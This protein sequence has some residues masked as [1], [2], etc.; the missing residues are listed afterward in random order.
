MRLPAPGRWLAPFAVACLS[1]GACDQVKSCVG[2][3][4]LA[5]AR[6]IDSS[7]PPITA[8]G[9]DTDCEKKGAGRELEVGP[10]KK[11]ASI[12]E[13][14]F[15]SLEAGDTV[16]IYHRPEPYREKIAIGG[17][18]RADAPIRV[19]GV[20][21]PN[22]ELPVLDGDG[23]TTR[24]SME[25]PF[26]GHQARGVVVVGWRRSLGWK[27]QTE[28]VVIEGLEIRNGSPAHRFK[29]KAGAEVAYASSAAGIFVQRGSH[30]V[31]RGNV[32]HDNANGLFVGSAGGEELTRDVLIERNYVFDNGSTT[33]YYEHNVY[34]EASG[35]VYQF[36]HFG[37][38]KRGR[39]GT[40]GGNIKER[41]ARVTIR[42]NWIEDGGHLIDLV[43]A[44]E[45]AESNLADPAFHESWVYGN[46]LVR[47]GVPGG[48]LVH[49]GGDSDVL[50]HYRKGTLHFFHN[51][52]VI[53][54]GAHERYAKSSIFELSTNDE[55]LDSANN[56]FMSDLPDPNRPIHLLGGRD[57]KTA[58]TASF[59]GDWIREGIVPAESGGK[60]D[61]KVIAKIEGFEGCAKGAD[62]RFANIDKRDFQP[63]SSSP[64]LSK[65]IVLT[66]AEGQTVSFEYVKPG[67][68]RERPPEASPTPGA[69]ALPN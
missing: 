42:Y 40:L 18:G 36:N 66:F 4:P 28:H 65:G 26:D 31:L 15:E 20:K 56:V 11:Y 44:Q 68:R 14:P 38:P 53:E 17:V 37:P 33:D 21:G 54:N 61:V 25:F 59:R 3:K 35:V 69:L 19:C 64:F 50:D 57:G 32:V 34:N 30:I 52:V 5:S 8:F 1:L 60:S 46:V 9:G 55:H 27:T 24:P 2:K 13:V 51:T 16:R 23:A 63:T 12:G 10:G 62:P 49:Y 45:A 58:G 29:D 41:S 43:D 67:G 7:P 6:P 47:G 39:E 48:S 22:G